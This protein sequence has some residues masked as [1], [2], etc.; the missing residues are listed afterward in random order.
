MFNGRE[1][2]TVFK[3][4]RQNIRICNSSKQVKVFKSHLKAH[5]MWFIITIIYHCQSYSVAIFIAKKMKPFLDDETQIK[6]WDSLRINNK[7][8]TALK[9][10]IKGAVKLFM[11]KLDCRSIKTNDIFIIPSWCINNICAQ[12]L[13]MNHVM[14]VVNKIINY[15]FFH[16]L[17]SINN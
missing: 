3:D 10:K 7:G 15:I 2:V 6:Y 4:T 14:N 17:F 11:Y 5:Y 9:Y 12:V 1:I 16:L 13:S 8:P